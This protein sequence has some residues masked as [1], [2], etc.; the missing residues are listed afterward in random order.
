M[1]STSQSMIGGRRLFSRCKPNRVSAT[2][3]TC[4]FQGRPIQDADAKRRRALARQVQIAFQ[5]PMSSL[6]PRMRL[7]DIVAEGLRHDDAVDRAQARATRA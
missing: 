6:D 5:D 7:R 2:A 4:R 1:A 3:F